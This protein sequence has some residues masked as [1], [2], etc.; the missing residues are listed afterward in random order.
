MEI[1]NQT[2]RCCKEMRG[3]KHVTSLSKT[4]RCFTVWLWCPQNPSEPRSF[5]STHYCPSCTEPGVYHSGLE[6]TS[7]LC[8][9]SLLAFTVAKQFCSLSR[10][11][12]TLSSWSLSSHIP[13]ILVI[14]DDHYNE[15]EQIYQS[16]RD[17]HQTNIIGMNITTEWWD[18]CPAVTGGHKPWQLSHD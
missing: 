13:V 18:K 17:G 8:I 7:H 3:H 16:P 12:W 2:Q 4:F 14:V 1:L 5:S 15:E 11:N 10:P 6:W 9:F